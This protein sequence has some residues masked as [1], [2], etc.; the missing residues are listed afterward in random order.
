MATITL[1]DI[2]NEIVTSYLD[3][4]K[5]LHAFTWHCAMGLIFCSLS[6]YFVYLDPGALGSGVPEVKRSLSVSARPPPPLTSSVTSMGCSWIMLFDSELSLPKLAPSSLLWPVVRVTLCLR[7]RCLLSGLFVGPEGPMVHVGA[8]IG[9]SISRLH[10]EVI[11]SGTHDWVFNALK[12]VFDLTTTRPH[13]L[14]Q[15]LP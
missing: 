8:I 9:A 13:D 15:P 2:K 12:N 11:L 5:W 14:T 4:G 1:V 10:T 7:L 3:N 6:F